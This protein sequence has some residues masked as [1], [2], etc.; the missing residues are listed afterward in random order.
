[1]EKAMLEQLTTNI[2]GKKDRLA[3]LFT[4]YDLNKLGYEVQ[5]SHCNDIRDKVL[6][7]NEFVMSPILGG[8]NERGLPLKVGDRITNHDDDWLMSDEDFERYQQICIAEMAKA[9]L[10]D[11]K[12]YYTQDWLQRKAN[13]W[14][15]LVDFIIDEILPDG[16]RKIFKDHRYS[17]TR[18]NQLLDITRPIVGC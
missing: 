3:E 4:L 1:M 10:T 9:G 7:E 18:M 5:E 2:V 15:E 13:S 12:G 17:V 6:K 14:S 16:L 11:E 8:G